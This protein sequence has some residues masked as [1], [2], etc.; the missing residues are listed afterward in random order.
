MYC[1][2]CETGSS[3]K[4]IPR[5]VNSSDWGH[6]YKA[7]R[8]LE[9]YASSYEWA[10]EVS[11]SKACEAI[12]AYIAEEKAYLVDGY[13][14]MTDEVEPWYSRDKVLQEWLVLKVYEGGCVSSIPE[15]LIEIAKSKGCKSVLSG[16]SSPVNIVGKAYE[17]AGWQPLTRLFTRKV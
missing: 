15:A 4:P 10:N 16:D 8:G 11:F 14:V 7:L 3:S 2:C 5:L 1:A 6:I 17:Q 12:R 13:L 9:R